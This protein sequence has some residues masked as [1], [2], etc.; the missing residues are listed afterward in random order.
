MPSQKKALTSD[1][2]SL[3]QM[4]EEIASMRA[5]LMDHAAEFAKMRSAMQRLTDRVYELEKGTND[6]SDATL[7]A[8]A[9]SGIPCERTEGG[10]ILYG[11]KIPLNKDTADVLC[12]LVNAS[13]IVSTEN[14]ATLCKPKNNLM[15]GNTLQPRAIYQRLRRL[16]M[17]LNN[18]HPNLGKECVLSIPRK[19][20]GPDGTTTKQG[21]IANDYRFDSKRFCEMLGI[22]NYSN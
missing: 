11:R 5:L 7:T 20:F 16:K 12:H 22:K 14:L 3:Q 13:G 10:V 19:E 17:A 18:Y 15:I 2:K 1:T 4:A 6:K 21:G 9:P 8:T